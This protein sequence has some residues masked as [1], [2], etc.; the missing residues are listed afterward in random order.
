MPAPA[1][2]ALACLCHSLHVGSLL[3]LLYCGGVAP[4]PAGCELSLSCML[5]AGMRRL[6]TL[7]VARLQGGCAIPTIS[8]ND[9]D[10]HPHTPQ[11]NP[12]HLS[13][14]ASMRRWMLRWLRS[15][16]SVTQPAMA[17]A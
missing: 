4:V 9:F 13:L 8:C 1:G 2:G 15:K 17:T 16:G 7:T 12:P 10:V 5:L 11:T 14:R 6:V 3:H